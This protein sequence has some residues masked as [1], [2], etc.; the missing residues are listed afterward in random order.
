MEENLH[1]NR[2]IGNYS[3]CYTGYTLNKKLRYRCS[4]GGIVTQLLIFFL[5][6]KI[7]D[8]A[9]VTRMKKDNP[10][11]PES[12]IAR[13]KKEVI[14]ARGSKYCP[15]SIHSGLKEILNS[16]KEEKFAVVGLP[17]HIKALRKLEKTKPDLKKKIISHI[18]LFCNH[19]PSFEAT[20][21]LLKRHK[22]DKKNVK[23]LSYRGHG[24]PGKMEIKTTDK[25]LLLLPSDY[26]PIIGAD[27][28]S[29]EK[30]KKCN[31]ATAE[32]ADI[33][34][35]DAWLP[36]FEKD[37]IGTSIIIC[38]NTTAQN[39]LN[40]MRK[41]NIVTIK[42]IN[43]QKV[44][45]SQIRPLCTKKRGFW[46][47]LSLFKNDPIAFLKCRIQLVGEKHILFNKVI[48]IISKLKKKYVKN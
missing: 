21:Y 25:V 22:I 3:Q 40:Q 20:K 43:I 36:E 24:W 45:E 39:I 2:L 29:L 16:K 23:F 46:N 31:D 6:R 41:E 1:H 32:L 38:R 30:C 47:Y 7:I 13:T 28:F 33:S 37:K 19:T 27:K 15:V 48:K 5:E 35:G 4:S 26:W 8:G 9:L 12:F 34:C 11:K 42:E 14:S 44:I 18:G 10:L 17:C